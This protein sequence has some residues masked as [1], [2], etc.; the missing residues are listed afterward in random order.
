LSLSV[1]KMKMAERGGFEPQITAWLFRVT[2][3]DNWCQIATF[4]NVSNGFSYFNS[5]QPDDRR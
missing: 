2:E 5:L 4:I 3:C 1:T